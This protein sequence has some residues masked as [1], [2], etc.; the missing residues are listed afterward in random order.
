MVAAVVLIIIWTI[1]VWG[2]WSM[3]SNSR[4]CEDGKNDGFG[5]GCFGA[6]LLWL[7]VLVL[8]VGAVYKC[9]WGAIV[10][11]LVLFLILI[12]IGVWWYSSC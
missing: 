7:I 12:L 9:A 1:G 3:Y 2:G 4:K 11:L 5:A 6:G 10:G 8:F